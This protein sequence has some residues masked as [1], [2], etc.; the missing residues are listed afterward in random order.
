MWLHEIAVFIYG[1][2]ERYGLLFC[3]GSWSSQCIKNKK[4]LI[5]L[6]GTGKKRMNL[7]NWSAT[8]SNLPQNNDQPVDWVDRWM[9]EFWEYSVCVVQFDAITKTHI[10]ETLVLWYLYLNP[11]GKWTYYNGSKFGFGWVLLI[12]LCLHQW[13]QS[14]VISYLFQEKWEI[15]S[16]DAWEGEKCDKRVW[17]HSMKWVL[18]LQVLHLKLVSQRLVFWGWQVLLRCVARVGRCQN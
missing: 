3:W 12:L 5:S 18:K 16:F 7:W 6:V 8:V 1:F 13:N 15:M 10:S 9:Y 11:T 4:H 2:Y 17:Q 14:F